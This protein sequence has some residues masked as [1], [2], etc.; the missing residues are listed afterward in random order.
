MASSASKLQLVL[1]RPR[2]FAITVI[3]N[4]V[5]TGEWRVSNSI[6][7][8]SA[9]WMHS[10]PRPRQRTNVVSLL[11]RHLEIPTNNHLSTVIAKWLATACR[12]INIVED[13]GLLEGQRSAWK[14]SYC[15]PR[16]HGFI[17]F[18]GQN[19]KFVGSWAG[20][21]TDKNSV[22]HRLLLL[23]PYIL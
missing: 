6:C 4:W 7:W 13:K 12:L 19:T 8:P 10:H 17:A 21:R 11:C 9:Q 22:I 3:V 20:I 2:L 15:I 16:R 14:N 1:R 23:N 18:E 5:T